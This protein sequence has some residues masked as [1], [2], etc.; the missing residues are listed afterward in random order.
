MSETT[1]AL[2]RAAHKKVASLHALNLFVVSW[3]SMQ[4]CYSWTTTTATATTTT[5][6]GWEKLGEKG[7][8]EVLLG[9]E[10]EG[11][12]TKVATVGCTTNTS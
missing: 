7:E 12:L 11:G 4:G 9:K 8:E 10:R 2:I 6:I 3:S 5:P 1:L